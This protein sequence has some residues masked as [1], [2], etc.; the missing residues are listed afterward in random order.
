MST[1]D[2][3][4]A[5]DQSTIRR[6]GVGLRAVDTDLASPGITVF[7]P[8]TG[9]G[10]VYAVDLEGNIVHTWESP[11]PPGRHARLLSNGNLFVQ[12]RSDGGDELFPLWPHYKGGDLYELAPDSSIVRAAQHP[13]HHHDATVLDNGNL[14]V[15]TLEPLA[16]ELAARVVGGHPGSEAPGGI[17]YGDCL[18]EMTWDGEVR[19]RWSP[20]EELGPEALPLDPAYGRA[21]WAVCNSVRE[22]ANGDLIVGY[23]SA[24]TVLILDRE[25]REVRWRLGP[26]VLA[27]QHDPHE[28]DNGNILIFDNGSFRTGVSWPYSRVIEVDRASKQIEWEYVDNPPQCFYS[29]YMGSAQRLPNGNTLIT[30]ASFGRIFEVT[31]GG[32]VV[33]EY[34]VPFFADQSPGAMRSSKTGEQNAVFRAHRYDS[35]AL[36]WLDLTPDRGDGTSGISHCE[37]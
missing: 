6:G 1:T 18:V 37:P 36:P 12:S 14:L 19:W 30:E 34:V 7:M 9:P 26:D 15:A 20:A 13:F 10:T 4:P 2:F 35:R 22:L 27:Q 33:W 5:V 29:P 21:H 17:I 23:R 32:E 11:G 28:L 31:S 16:P 25:T 8:L 3:G 24:S